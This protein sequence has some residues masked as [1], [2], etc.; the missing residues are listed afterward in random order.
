MGPHSS[1]L[2]FA[3]PVESFAMRASR[4][5]RHSR[6]RRPRP[7]ARLSSTPSTDAICLLMRRGDDT[8]SSRRSGALRY[9]GIAQ[10]EGP[11]RTL[12]ATRGRQSF[13]PGGSGGLWGSLR[14]RSPSPTS[15]ASRTQHT[16]TS[17]TEDDL[18]HSPAPPYAELA[19]EGA[20]AAANHKERRP[21][22]L[23]RILLRCTRRLKTRQRRAGYARTTGPCEGA[24]A[25]AA[26]L[27]APPS[28]KL[29]DTTVAPPLAVGGERHR[30][31]ALARLSAS[32]LTRTYAARFTA[33]LVELS[34]AGLIKPARAGVAT[35]CRS[36][37]AL[38]RSMLAGT[39]LALPLEVGREG[40]LEPG[41]LEPVLAGVPVWEAPRCRGRRS[42][43][44][45][46]LVGGRAAGWRW[47]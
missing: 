16:D 43:L 21:R 34:L 23:G 8:G 27:H 31:Q 30:Q 1:V 7:Q 19:L 40:L 11:S 32:A 6:R 39:S 36:R 12:R 2:M 4:H 10:W 24:L 25:P 41:L 44:S 37:G 5:S 42:I 18:A 33:L 20:R 35:S 45:V 22:R 15:S 17:V 28:W 29:L 47:P 13:A 46:P 14:V 26:L 9:D 38:C 3:T